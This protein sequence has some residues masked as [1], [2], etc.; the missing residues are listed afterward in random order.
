MY[1]ALDYPQ[2]ADKYFNIYPA[3]RDEHLYRWYGGNF[4]NETLGKP[5]NPLVSEDF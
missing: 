5:L 4:Q 3:T 2:L 1:N